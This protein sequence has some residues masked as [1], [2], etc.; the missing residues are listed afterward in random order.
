M[1]FEVIMAVHVV[2]ESA[3]ITNTDTP[4]TCS[5]V[6]FEKVLRKSNFE[7]VGNMYTCGQLSTYMQGGT[8]EIQTPAHRTRSAA[9]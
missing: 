1:E 2:Q 8:V 6:T 3:G 5:I 7:Q 4:P 9:A